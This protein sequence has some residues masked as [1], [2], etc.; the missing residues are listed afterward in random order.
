MGTFDGFFLFPQQTLFL[1]LLFKLLFTYTSST[2][3]TLNPSYHT[4]FGQPT[5]LHISGLITLPPPILGSQSANFSK[6]MGGKTWNFSKG[7]KKKNQISCF[8]SM[9]SRKLLKL[10]ESQEY[11]AK[12]LIGRKSYRSRPTSSNFLTSMQFIPPLFLVILFSKCFVIVRN[13]THKIST[14]ISQ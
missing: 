12:Y 6:E 11:K 1:Y 8:T 3:F 2:F 10:N 7:N 9:N 4:I 13:H 5:V 14:C